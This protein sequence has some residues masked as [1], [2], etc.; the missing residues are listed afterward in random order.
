[1]EI[2]HN[3]GYEAIDAIRPQ[4]LGN[5]LVEWFYQQDIVMFAKGGHPVLSKGFPKPQ[6]F[7]HPVLYQQVLEMQ[8]SLGRIV[9]TLPSAIY[10]SIRYRLGDH[11]FLR[12]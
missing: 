6:S 2:F 7:V 9:K 8:P 5:D 12:A 1:M 3:H 10:R 4:I 11:N